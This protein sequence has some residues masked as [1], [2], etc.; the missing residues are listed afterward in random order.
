[1]NTQIVSTDLVVIGAGHAGLTTAICAAEQG[2]QVTILEVAPRE[3]RGGNSRHTRNLRPMHEGPAAPMEGAYGFEE[4]MDDLLKVTDGKTDKALAELTVKNSA[5]AVAWLRDHG[6]DFQAPLGGT[7]HLGRTNAFFMGGGKAMVNSLFRAAA[8]LGVKI[9]YQAENIELD[10]RGG[11]FEQL[12]YQHRGQNIIL[13]AKVMVAASGG[14]EANLEWLS[15]AWGEAANNFIVRGTPYNRGAILRQLLA[16]GVGQIGDV[17]QCHAVAVDGRAPKFDGGICSRIDCVSLGIVV[18][19]K[20]QRFYDEGEDFWPKRYAIWGRLVA[21]QPDQCAYAII[22]AQSEGLFMPT[23]FAPVEAESITQ[24][25]RKLRL[26]AE[27]LTN[28]VNTYNEAVRGG[29]FNHQELDNCATDGL[30]IEK[31]HWARRIEQPPFRA[32]IL[33]PGITFTYLGVNVDAH[34]R[35][36]MGNGSPSENMY[37]AGEIMAGNI[38]G[39]GYLAGVGVTIGSVFGRIAG[40]EA[41]QNV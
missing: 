10:I 30:K 38:L 6:V 8:S 25:A 29:S 13:D 26:S 7:L 5:S 33:R 21:A 31:T 4:Y 23:V 15:E 11:Q 27:A 24:L 17:R 9:V 37:A 16:A 3:V 32:Y 39:Q 34:A 36:R 12:H 22:D 40:L 19:N 2:I 20:A 35:I 18:N 41:S 1:M 28:T 14:F